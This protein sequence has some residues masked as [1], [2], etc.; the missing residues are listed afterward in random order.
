MANGEKEDRAKYLPTPEELEALKAEIK[1]EGL[2]RKRLSYSDNNP[3]LN[4]V[5]QRPIYVSPDC[6]RETQT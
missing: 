2:E 4:I 5:Y 6:I 1:A 3:E